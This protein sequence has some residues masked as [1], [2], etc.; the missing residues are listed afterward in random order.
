MEFTDP[1]TGHR[2][3]FVSSRTLDAWSSYDDWAAG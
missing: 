2:H 3:R 1:V